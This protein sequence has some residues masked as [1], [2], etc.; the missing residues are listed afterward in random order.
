V[1]RKGRVY[2]GEYKGNNGLG[3]HI[4]PLILWHWPSVACCSIKVQRRTEYT[5]PVW[6]VI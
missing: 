4:T 6:L 1:R 5:R 3:I 2:T